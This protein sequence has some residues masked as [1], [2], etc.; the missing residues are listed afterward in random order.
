MADPAGTMIDKNTRL[1]VLIV[2]DQFGLHLSV[3]F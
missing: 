2:T 1:M 3:F